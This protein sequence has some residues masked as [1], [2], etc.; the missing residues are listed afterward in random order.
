[1]S[2]SGFFDGSPKAS[3]LAVLVS[4]HFFGRTH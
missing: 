2:P 3:P 1:M 4:V